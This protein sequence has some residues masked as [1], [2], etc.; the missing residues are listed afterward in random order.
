MA[1]KRDLTQKQFDA[2]CAARG[3]Q[4]DLLG[5]YRLPNSSVY[6]HAR[7]AGPRRRSQLAY[8][9]QQNEQH[10]ADSEHRS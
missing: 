5:Y 2:A 1:T 7:N 10:L 8:L 9:I 4:R 3:F 6:V